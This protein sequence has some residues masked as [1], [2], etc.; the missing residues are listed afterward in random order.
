MTRTEAIL[1]IARTAVEIRI[2]QFFIDGNHRTATLFVYEAL[3]TLGINFNGFATGVYFLLSVAGE[4][5]VE[6]GTARLAEVVRRSSMG[7]KRY[8]ATHHQEAVK[9]IPVWASLAFNILKLLADVKTPL[10]DRRR[11]VR[12]SKRNEFW[13]YIGIALLR[14]DGRQVGP[15]QVIRLLR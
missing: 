7:S 12:H 9:R 13:L 5:G 2:G 11:L 1:E 15:R 10:S 14:G 6:L 8:T 3:S 4:L